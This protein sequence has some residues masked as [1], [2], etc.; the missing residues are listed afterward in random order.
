MAWGVTHL[1]RV[2]AI[3]RLDPPNVELE[4][5][6]GQR[7]AIDLTPYL[8]E[9]I[10]ERVRSDPAYFAQVRVHPEFRTLCWPN[11]ADIDPDVLLR[12]RTPA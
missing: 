11:G 3:V 8:S 9:E 7:R 10:F 4:L 1:L 6:D 2:R 5:T 12:G